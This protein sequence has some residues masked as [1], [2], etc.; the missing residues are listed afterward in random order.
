[1]FSLNKRCLTFQCRGQGFTLAEVLIT[2]MVIGILAV[3][4]IPSILQS[5]EE[6][7]TVSQLR[8]T[9]SVLK[10]A[11]FLAEQQY[12]PPDTWNIGG[13]NVFDNLKPYLHVVKTCNNKSFGCVYNQK[14]LQ[15]NDIEYDYNIGANSDSQ[16]LLSDGV[17]IASGWGSSTCTYGLSGGAA[18]G[19]VEGNYACVSLLVDING[20]KPPNTFGKD[21]FGFSLTKAGILPWGGKSTTEAPTQYNHSSCKVGSSGWGCS[22]WVIERGN[23]EYLHKTTT[24]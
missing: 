1:M 3:V 19:R 13:G 15:L 7:A 6:R 24:W 18:V 22:R 14:Y 5:W 2:L 12:G 20:P 8:K 17:G 9:Y 21:F 11:Y 23:M 4:T 10:Q 16:I